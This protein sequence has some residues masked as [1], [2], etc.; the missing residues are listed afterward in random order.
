M[1]GAVRYCGSAAGR[2]AYRCSGAG[3][4]LLVDPG[5]VTHL[6]AMSSMAGFHEVIA[7]LGRRFRVIRFDKPGCGLS[8]RDPPDLSFEGQVA[9]A[10]AV[11]DAAHA[12]RFSVIGA[13][14][15][16]QVAV[17]LAAR[18]PARV[19][20]LVLYGTCADGRELAPA[21]VRTSLL[22]LVSAHWGLG[23][24]VLADI[25]LS[26]VTDS[27]I[28]A[29]ARLQRACASP[30][31][32]RSLLEVYYATDVTAMLDHVRSRTAVLHRQGDTATRF[33]LGRH[34]ASRIE[35]ATLTALPGGGHLFYHGAWKP[36]LDAALAF[37]IADH[38]DQPQLTDREAQVARLV[39]V[40]LT[41]QEIG[42]RLGVAARTADT[43]VQNIRH[44]LQVRSRAQI[45]TW[46]TE[47]DAHPTD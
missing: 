25:F 22:D 19:R 41:T 23:S 31:V 6:K 21:P 32:A 36:V 42:A 11:A 3:P 38:P 14:Q 13:S 5:W 28:E 7:G 24:R 15:G 29:F 9:A 8:D 46:I 2:I 4:A 17:A 20:S 40:G 44:K 35:G 37:L 34:L 10:L 1:A 33:E 47:H 18:Y 26:D 43:H 16:G 45:A 12:D 30:Q 39:A 27:D